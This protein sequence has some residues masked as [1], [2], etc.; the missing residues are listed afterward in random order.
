MYVCVCRA[1]TEERVKAAIDAG[2]ESVAAVT[3]ACCAGDDC[4][5]CH[6]TIEDMIEERCGTLGSAKRLPVVRAA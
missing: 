4:G 2:A 5:A 1:V 3:A 6:Q